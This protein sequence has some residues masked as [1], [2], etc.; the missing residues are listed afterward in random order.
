ML[1]AVLKGRKDVLFLPHVQSTLFP[2][3]L[4]LQQFEII[5]QATLP[6]TNHGHQ[7]KIWQLVSRVNGALLPF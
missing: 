5:P 7:T 4:K 2:G 6:S 3:V 1:A